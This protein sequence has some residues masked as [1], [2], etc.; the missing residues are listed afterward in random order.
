MN[1]VLLVTLMVEWGLTV[2]G[3]LAFLALYG[4]PGKYADRTMAWHI[5]SVTAVAAAE[6]GGL[7][8]AAIGVALWLWL[9]AVIYGIAG[10]VV[11]WRLWLLVRSVSAARA[12]G[13]IPGASPDPPD[14]R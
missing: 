4:R 1:A 11:Y 8:L 12:S 7:L 3:G 2:A 9:F 5:V 6:A 14:T 10:A 13:R